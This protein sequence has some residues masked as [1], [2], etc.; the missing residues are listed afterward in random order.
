[1]KALITGGTGFV[2]RNL[3]ARI[4]ESIIAGRNLKKIN[5]I[6]H[7]REARQ[8][9]GSSNIDPSFLEGVDTIFHLAGESIF[10]GRWNEEKKNGSVPVG[11]KEH[12]IWLIQ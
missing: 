5:H 8:W 12:V 2:G 6:F 10:Q 3:A 11:L 7:D 1:M 4:P 9:D